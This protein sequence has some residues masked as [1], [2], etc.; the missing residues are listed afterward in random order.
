MKRLLPSPDRDTLLPFPS[1]EHTE[2]NASWLG[3]ALGVSFTL[4]FITGFLSHL[5]QY[6]PDW[7]TWPNRPT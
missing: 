5:I 4:C 2:R 7:F 3:I 6:P 1:D